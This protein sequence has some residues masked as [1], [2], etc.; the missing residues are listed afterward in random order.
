[1]KKFP[2][3]TIKKIFGLCSILVLIQSAQAQVT[4]PFYEPFPSSYGNTNLGAPGPGGVAGTG[5]ATNWNFGNSVGGSS[6]KI[7]NAAALSYPGLANIDGAGQTYGLQSNPGDLTSVK[8]RGVALTIPNTNSTYASCLLNLQQLT[9]SSTWVFFG[10]SSTSSGTSVN[11]SGANVFFDTSGRLL[12]AKNSTTPATN[13]TAA[14][15]VG[16][17]Y[18]VVLRYQRNTNG[19]DQVDLWLDPTSLGD[20]TKIPPPNITTTNNSNPAAFASVAYFQAALPTLFN[21]DEIRVATNWAGVTPTGPSPGPTFNVTGGGAGCPGDAF[22]VGLSGSVT[23]NIYW[24]YINSAFSGQTVSGNP[25]HR[26]PESFPPPAPDGCA[27]ARQSRGSHTSPSPCR[28]LHSLAAGSP[29]PRCQ[30]AK[31]S[32]NYPLPSARWPRSPR[33]DSTGLHT[34]SQTPSRYRPRRRAPRRRPS[35]ESSRV[36]RAPPRA[37]GSD[38]CAG[39]FPKSN[40]EIPASILLSSQSPVPRPFR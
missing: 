16:N 11:H 31:S 20:D 2:T 27:N 33:R 7:T 4:L 24:L 30:P 21:L 22:A 34:G 9:N 36:L 26:R 18:L 40:R 23:T 19:I 1:M 10:L 38:S 28:P 13:T 15:T 32:A 12:I 14:L 35:F 29:C 3:Q 6:A 39:T 8:D 37:T 5:S 25:R 17:T